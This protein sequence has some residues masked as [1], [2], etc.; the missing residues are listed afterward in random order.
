MQPERN[1]NGLQKEI[2]SAGPVGHFR[3]LWG[4]MVVAKQGPG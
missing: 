3:G 4:R 1:L 2:C